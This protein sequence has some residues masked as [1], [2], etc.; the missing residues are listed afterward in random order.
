MRKEFL[1]SAGFTG[2]CI[3]IIICSY[4]DMTPIK[5]AHAGEIY[6]SYEE[7]NLLRNKNPLLCSHLSRLLRSVVA[8]L[9]SFCF[10]VDY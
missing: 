2:V 1:C 5:S 4:A 3:I 10:E 7:E 8:T 9:Y 6:D